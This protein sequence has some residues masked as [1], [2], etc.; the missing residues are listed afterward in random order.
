MS[1]TVN[2]STNSGLHE[3]LSYVTWQ[4][5]CDPSD[6]LLIV[7]ICAHDATQSDR[8]VSSVVH[9]GEA[10]SKA[11]SYDNGVDYN[12]EIWYRVNP[13]STGYVYVTFG[14]QVDDIAGYAISLEGADTADPLGNY[15]T[16]TGIY[17]DPTVTVASTTGS[18]VVG[19]MMITENANLKLT[20]DDTEIGL[21]DLGADHSGAS[22]EIATGSSVILSWTYTE[23]DQTYWCL[24][25]EFY[26]DG[27]AP[28]PSEASN[29]MLLGVG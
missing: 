28:P 20:C 23:D 17:S 3:R 21:D 5:Y 16:Y 18:I 15:N 19:G 12:M 9:N 13:D 27:A 22:Y 14:G 4:H 2:V 26:A 24:A 8:T 10:C 7:V 6:D 11:R 29:L 25:Q 1:I